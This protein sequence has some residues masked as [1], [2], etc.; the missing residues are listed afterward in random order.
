MQSPQF[1]TKYAGSD[2]NGDVFGNNDRVGLEPRNTFLGDT[3]QTVDI[4]LERS[5][6]IRETMKLDVLGEIFNLMNTVNIRYFNTTYGASD[7]CPADPAAP[8]CGGSTHAG[9]LEGSPNPLY[10]TP[11]SVNNPRQVQ[12][13]L[14]L[15]F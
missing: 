2:V 11:S 15:T 1:F 9:S 13:A 5:F 8:G 10:G 14:R 7:F 3:L 12:L 4:R 6:P